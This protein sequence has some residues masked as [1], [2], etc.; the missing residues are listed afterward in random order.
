[1]SIKRNVYVYLF[2]GIMS[3]ALWPVVLEL[4]VNM[5]ILEFTLLAYAVAVP[6]SIGFARVLGKK[7]S[8]RQMLRNKTTFLAIV[9]IGILNYGFQTSGMLLGEHFISASLAAVLFRT[10]PLLMLPFLPLVLKEHVSKIQIF[11][12]SLGVA[13]MFLAFSNTLGVAGSPS[14]MAAIAVTS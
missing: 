2:I 14:S 11:S 9:V 12:M 6:V 5:D 10:Y 1:M 3:A 4:A 8:I 7:F 13:G